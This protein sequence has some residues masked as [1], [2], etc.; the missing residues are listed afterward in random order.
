[1]KKTA[2]IFVLITMAAA[3][4]LG[5]AGVNTIT[6]AYAIAT[7]EVENIAGAV[8][9]EYPQVEEVFVNA[10]L[11]EENST[12]AE[13]RSIMS[14]YGYGGA[15]VADTEK[16]RSIRNYI[17]MLSLFM[18]AVIL[19]G[20]TAITAAVRR[21]QRQEEDMLAILDSCF[22]DDYSFENDSERLNA[23]GNQHFADS[24]SKLGSKLKMK[25]QQLDSEQDSTKTLVTD[26]SHQLKTP[27]SAMKT[28]FDMYLEADSQ[29]EKDEFLYRSM[30]QMDRLESLAAALINISRLETGMIELKTEKASLTEIIITALNTVYQKSIDK[31]I[32]I[33]TDEF[34]DMCLELDS[35][36]TAE[37]IANLLDNG[38]KYSPAGSR[39][40]IR[41]SRLYSFVRIEIEDRGIGIPKN[42]QNRIFRRFYRGDNDTVRA[43]EGSGVGLY[44]SRTIIE[45]QDGTISVRSAEGGGSTFI[46]QLPLRS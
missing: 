30:A 44:L 38:I 28:C 5:A 35:R 16:K 29:E 4:V 8:L 43:Q 1:M 34:D 25:T 24:L 2:V 23:L 7:E 13:G 21:R 32:V 11:D 45:R 20:L 46:I 37:A 18:S 42:E 26:I 15:S 31:S 22:A 33:E 41:V 3:V 36:W 17:I 19:C 14:R 6:N 10:A 39:I 9:A 12:L 40:E 27:I